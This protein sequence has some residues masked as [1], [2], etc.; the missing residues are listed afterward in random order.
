[1]IQKKESLKSVLTQKAE[2]EEEMRDIARII[3]D[4]FLYNELSFVVFLSGGL[5]SGKTFMTREIL[6]CAEITDPVTSPTFTY[7]EEYGPHYAH[8][9]F[10]RFS[11]P[12]E[13]FARGFDEIASDS[14][15]SCLVEWGDHISETAQECFTGKHLW[16]DIT[17]ES[18]GSR[19]VE[20]FDKK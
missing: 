4:R 18:D 9:D 20:V 15:V 14:Q 8:F 19:T 5:G 7:V 3:Y 11:E 17:K 1:M 12:D 10:Y 2:N 6:R 16:V 13:F